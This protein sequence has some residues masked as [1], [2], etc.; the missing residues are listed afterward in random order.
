[1]TM[2]SWDLLQGLGAYQYGWLTL[3]VYVGC[4]AFKPHP[5]FEFVSDMKCFPCKKSRW[6]FIM[7]ALKQLLGETQIN[8]MGF[9]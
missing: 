8:K 5:L 1:M 2:A 6:G 4:T 3:H 9:S 7:H